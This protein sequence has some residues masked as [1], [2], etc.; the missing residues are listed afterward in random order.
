MWVG[1]LSLRIWRRLASEKAE[2]ESN[3]KCNAGTNHTEMEDKDNIM[4][5]EIQIFQPVSDQLY[6]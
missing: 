4:G 1:K 2:A 6:I 5:K 3:T